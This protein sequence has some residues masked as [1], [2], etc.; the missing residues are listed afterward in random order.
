MRFANNSGHLH[1][2]KCAYQ[3]CYMEHFFK[4]R[5][6]YKINILLISCRYLISNKPFLNKNRGFMGVTREN[7][8]LRQVSKKT[9]IPW[10]VE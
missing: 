1:E 10:Q 2:V 9:R 8:L 7:N 5:D 4:K 3:N 6:W